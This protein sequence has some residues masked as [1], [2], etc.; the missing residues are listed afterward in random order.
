MPEMNTYEMRRMDEFKS[1]L[2]TRILRD[3][4][5]KRL[6]HIRIGVINFIEIELSRWDGIFD[7]LRAIFRISV[8]VR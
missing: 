3:R 1:F 5:N 7:R 2:N 8:L 6:C 4:P